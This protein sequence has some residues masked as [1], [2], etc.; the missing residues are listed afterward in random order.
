[1]SALSSV[2]SFARAS[3]GR[4]SFGAM[5][6]SGPAPD[7]AWVSKF[8][9]RLANGTSVTVTV[10]PGFA[11]LTAATILSNAS[12][13]ALPEA[14][15]ASQ[16][17]SVPLSA[18]AVGLAATDVPADGTA[19]VADDGCVV[20]AVVAPLLHALATSTTAPINAPN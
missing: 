11:V 6:R 18:A 17:V 9:N 5:Y 16:I 1:M 2:S 14:P 8:V 20:G 15:Y 12:F 7:A 3:V 10:S 13:S 4:L 19:D